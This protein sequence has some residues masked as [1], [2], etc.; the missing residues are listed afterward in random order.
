MEEDNTHFDSK[1]FDS[2]ITTYTP[3]LLESSYD[4]LK[5]WIEDSL[6]LFKNDLLPLLYP[7]FVHIYF[8][9]IQQNKT[10]EA[11]EF[12]KTHVKDHGNKREE[13]KHFESIYTLQHI[14]ENNLAY[15]FRTSKYKLPMGRYAFD[16]LLNF[17]EENNFT[18][19]LKI[20]NQYLHI[21]IYSGAKSEDR[22]EGIEVGSIESEVDLTT[23]LVSKE[24]E[25]AILADEQYKYDHLETYATQLKKQREAKD[26]ESF[27]KPN[28]SQIIAEIEKLKDLCKR[29]S[30]NKK[31]LPSICCYTVH[32]TYEGLTCAEISN[33]SKLL[34]CGFKD[35]FIDIFSLTKEP[36]K[37][38]KKSADL[39]KSDI[40]NSEGEKFEEVGQ[41][42]RLIGHS[43]PVYCVKFFSSNKFLL[44][45]SQDC[46]VR[47]WSLDT[48]SEVGVYKTHVFPV[49]SVDVAPNDFYF[50]S[51]SADRQTVIW[52][53]T[54]SKPERLIVTALSDVTVVKFHPNSKYLF[55]GSSDHKIR[56]HDINSA[57]IVRTFAGH[58]DTVTCLD[59]SHCGKL[60]VSG[61]KDKSLIL[62]D[63]QNGRSLIKYTGHSSIIFSVSFSWYG[64]IIASCG[65][66]NCVKLWD[67]SDPKGMCL[68]TYYTKNTPLLC[69][70]F[71]YRNIISTTGPFIGG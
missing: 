57:Q 55:T 53:V 49:W 52:A 62:W 34:A 30:V 69:V 56:M 9:L 37:R 40:K 33:D 12:Y 44:S 26:K 54:G 18:Y 3:G 71:G 17:L 68:G 5:C 45:C 2:N 41:S 24:C 8:D 48:L 28:A 43:G 25:E 13:L 31:N 67:K 20:L 50:A 51:G 66:D 32:N 47:L 29:V 36:L 58:T 1:N 63:I 60:L 39:A 22:P 61:G 11:K 35:S 14:N 10:E 7:L 42:F 19:I 65:A 59:I 16:L 46:T 70:K 6:D 23:F 27:I 38:M 21:N 15:T 64:T 4:K